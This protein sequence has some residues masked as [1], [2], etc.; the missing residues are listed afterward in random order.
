MKTRSFHV[1]GSEATP[2]L[3][4]VLRQRGQGVTLP[5]LESHSLKATIL[6]WLCKCGAFALSERQVLGHYLDRPSAR[7]LTYVWGTTTT[8]Q[9]TAEQLKTYL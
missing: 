3:R 5:L 2:H 7:A 4:E 6:S 9:R 1:H 8:T